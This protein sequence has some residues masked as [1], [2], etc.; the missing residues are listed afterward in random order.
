VEEQGLLQRYRG[1]ERVVR[2]EVRTELQSF[3]EQGGWKEE[4][5]GFAAM[6]E[7]LEF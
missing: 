2:P 5:R 1:K 7:G 4:K 6:G 3:I